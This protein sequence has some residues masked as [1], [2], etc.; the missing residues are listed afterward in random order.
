MAPEAKTQETK[1]QRDELPVAV[2]RTPRANDCRPGDDR[3]AEFPPSL[4]TNPMPKERFMIVDGNALLHRAWHALPPLTTSSGEIVNAV[5]GFL[6][7]FLKAVKDI[8]P[9]HVAA[10][11]DLKGP[12]FR[13][14]QYVEYKA[15][16]V[17]QPDELYMQLDRIK[18]VVR[19]LGILIFERKGF[20]ADD[21]IA[22]LCTRIANERPSAEI[23]IVTGDMDALQLVNTQTTVYCPRRG[24]SDIALY[25]EKAV[26]ARYGGLQPK[27]LV[28]YKALRGDVSDNIP[29]VKGIGE[30]TAIELVHRYGTVDNMLAAA[31]D[32]I[33]VPFKYAKSIEKIVEQKEMAQMSRML[34]ELIHDVPIDFSFEKC[35]L[36]RY[37]HE[38]VIQLFQELEFKSLIPRLSDLPDF[39]NTPT[40]SNNSSSRGKSSV[41]Y[42][43]IESEK[44]ALV[45]IA[46]L[47]EAKLF[48]FDTETTST[49]AID[50]DVV[51]VSF[52]KK[53]AEAFYIP[54]TLEG[55]EWR[56]ELKKL[57]EDPTI[58]KVGHNIKYD[59][60]VMHRVD[61]ALSGVVFDS[62]IAAYII[63]PGTREY[64]LD[65]LAFAEFGYQKI[66]ITSL[67]GAGKN[68]K[69]MAEVAL[70]DISPY[71]CEDADFTLRLYTAFS[72]KLKE[73]GQE[74]L[75]NEMELPLI[76]VLVSMEESGIALDV[77]FVQSCAKRV[78]K[79]LAE[80]EKKI[81]TL[82]G[83]EFNIG[84][85]LQLKKI[86]FEKLAISTNRIKK[87]KTGLST[88][89]SELEK[90]RLLHPIIDA[91]VQY[92]E[93]SKLLNTYIDVLP[94][95]VRPA[96]GRIHTSYNQ[97][98]TTTGRLSSS[99]PN[100]Q[101]IPIRQEIGRELRKGFIAT[102]GCTLLSAD[103]SQ[104]ELRIV[105]SLAKD[106]KM[107]EAFKK[108]DDIHTIT[109]AL[110]Q[111]VKPE[112]V[113][114]EMRRAAKEVN[115]GILYGMGPQGLAASAGISFGEAQ[116]FIDQYF[117]AYPGVRA[118]L[119]ETIRIAREKG[120]V[121]TLFG[122]RRY[123][124]EL[125]SSMPQ[126]RNAAER[127]AVN[128]P[129]QGTEADIIKFAM[130]AVHKE[131]QKIKNVHLLLQVHDE[132]VF[133]VANDVVQDVAT[134]IQKIMESVV[135]LE[136]PVIV[137]LKY[138][139]NW[140]EMKKI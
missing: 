134:K 49:I 139:P 94:T 106:I 71:A 138:G 113:T 38:K 88:A 8:S 140:G 6:S 12:T 31:D 62:M 27:Q 78:K 16:R 44:D 50:A 100:L 22:T 82:A 115:F 74:K 19:A 99:N 57:L 79:E 11:F 59:I 32:E 119:D 103:Y 2:W 130:I 137:D 76:D 118:Y 30:K 104:I 105:A 28:E 125:Q 81:Y 120:Y 37:D 45:L 73:N 96:T 117:V 102:P 131:I 4:K 9:T 126:V 80:I 3:R 123:V 135:T 51:G 136:V 24:I 114:H 133:E 129:I 90:M 67:I 111:G 48:S 92:R 47:H 58:A 124:P 29:G 121:E 5:Y 93:Y 20:E 55:R 42:T 23:V 84:S 25:D 109:A 13:H 77:P 39:S 56:K 60:E 26:S 122:R 101:N 95:L 69:S 21:V 116:Q 33:G 41:I 86:L 36:G 1:V 87:G 46:E 66:P 85:P 64:G 53:E 14:V 83:E 89:A 132:L 68:Q 43:C 18:T 110:I 112:E 35:A 127:A 65:A 128:M 63:N 98:I 91:I 54:W 7:I 61:V 97:T 40:Y 34:V 108:G 52:S 17:K 107:I 72:K 75:L 70:A 10:T 15:T